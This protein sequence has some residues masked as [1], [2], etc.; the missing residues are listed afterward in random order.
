MQNKIRRAKFDFSRQLIIQNTSKHHTYGLWC[1]S[2]LVSR[3]LYFFSALLNCFKAASQYSQYRIRSYLSIEVLLGIGTSNRVHGR[4]VG[5]RGR[6]IGR[7][8]SIGLSRG[9]FIRR[10][11]SVSWNRDGKRLLGPVGIRHT[12]I[13]YN[14]KY[15]F[16]HIH[17]L[18][19]HF[20]N[21][22]VPTFWWATVKHTRSVRREWAKLN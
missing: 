20:Q 4:L 3:H 19:L 7:R 17:V 10:S 6:G 9:D 21:L 16:T 14:K 11:C 18:W 8:G 12:T 1:Y 22:H 5:V 2:S 15:S 13:E